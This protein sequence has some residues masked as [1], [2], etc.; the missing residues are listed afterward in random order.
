[1]SPRYIIL[2]DGKP[3]TLASYVEAWRYCRAADPATF[4]RRTP[5]GWPGYAGEALAQFRGGLHDRINR[6]LPGYGTGR[7]W[8]DDWQRETLQAASRLNTPRLIIDWLPPH[9]KG[10]FSHRLRNAA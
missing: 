3:V 1:M 10:R 6:H 9:L 4:L 5:N 8:S 7:K 2:G